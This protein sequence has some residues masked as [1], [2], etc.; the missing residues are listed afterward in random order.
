MPFSTVITSTSCCPAD[1]RVW[2]GLFLM[3]GSISYVGLY[4]LCWVI[5]LMLGSISYIVQVA[6][7]AA[8]HNRQLSHAWRALRSLADEASS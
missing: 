4:F 1:W 3:S 8:F 5:F 6:L 7:F 2:C